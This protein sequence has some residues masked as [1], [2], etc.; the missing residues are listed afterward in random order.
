LAKIVQLDVRLIAWTHFEPPAGVRWQT[1]ADGGQALAEFAGRACYQAWD[2]NN[3]ATASNAGYLQ[4]IVQVGHLAVFE[5][6]TATFYIT[7]L[8][9]SVAHEVL[10]HRHLSVS[11]L[12]SR[13][14]P[15][16][17]PA[18]V[19]PDA[20]AADAA[21]HEQFV[22]SVGAATNA[23]AALRDGLEQVLGAT[24]GAAPA[25]KQAR[26]LARAVLP[27]A[28]ETQLVVTGNLRAWRH[29]V[30]VRGSEHADPA[31]RAV[32]L[33]CLTHLSRLA[34]NAFADFERVRL[35]DGTEVTTA[36]L[37]LEG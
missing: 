6:A 8:A 11:Q 7:G 36:P 15:A 21:L 34:P 37:A 2:R 14:V 28:T 3:P 25:A 12:S 19:E 31:V 30:A 13:H 9:H 22:A 32:A 35:P 16:G 10:R 26:Q 33:G 18:V 24:H 29:F 4:H 20:V 1:D 17:E 23:H 5:H 27:D